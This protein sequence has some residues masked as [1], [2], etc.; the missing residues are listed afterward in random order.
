MAILN[1]LT[2]TSH[3][4]CPRNSNYTH[5]SEGTHIYTPYILWAGRH[6]QEY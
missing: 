3:T 6:V 2:L 5:I 1:D 4:L